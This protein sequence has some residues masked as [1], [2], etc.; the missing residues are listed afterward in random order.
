VEQPASTAAAELRYRPPGDDSR[1][2]RWRQRREDRW[3]RPAPPR[4][5][6]WA[7][8]GVGK[9][10][11]VLGLLMF[12][13]VG[14]QLWG[15][16]IQTAQAQ[17]KLKGEFHD[18]LA[19]LESTGVVSPPDTSSIDTAPVDPAVGDTTPA[20]SAP[21]GS[22]PAGTT[23]PSE[24]T[25]ASDP[26][27][28]A[29]GGPRPEV[30][31]PLALLDAPGM[32][33]DDWVVIEGIGTAQLADGIGH[34]PDTPLPGEL[35]NSV[36]AAHRTTH[37]APFYDIDDL[38]VGDRIEL[39]TFAGHFAYAVTG[40]EIVDPSEADRVVS[41]VDPA[42]A[43]LTLVSCHPAYTTRQ[44]YIVHAELIDAESDAPSR[45]PPV[46]SS[47]VEMVPVTSIGGADPQDTLPGEEVPVDGPTTAEGSPDV[48]AAGDTE[49]LT[50]G[51][52]SDPAAWPQVIAW[53]LVLVG[54]AWGG[55]LLARRAQR[56]WVGALV[57][58]VPFVVALYFWY[59]NVNR[60]LPPGF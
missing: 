55:W 46:T 16:A 7:V 56:L 45:P 20:G 3:N 51:W 2:S 36:L 18:Q 35:G 19:T 11:I 13:F 41:T 42:R 52:F 58:L 15:T 32:D 23:P 28:P 21:V 6:R 44:R 12:G 10:L 1:I 47:P 22:A 31:D 14:Y 34:F 9:V 33:V 57:A 17:S 5:W 29:A 40:T 38:G 54:L 50:E 8:G 30:G 4:D 59:E 39:Q 43:T 49:V 53:G 37:G 25:S 24:P 60:L 48:T 26:A 27:I